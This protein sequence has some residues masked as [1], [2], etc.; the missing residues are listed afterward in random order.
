MKNGFEIE[1]TSEA[2]RNLNSIFDYLENSWSEREIS[3]FAKKMESDLKI[4]SKHPA[5]FPYF[6]KDKNVRRC[7]LTPQ[8]TIYYREIPSENRVVIITLFDNRQNPDNLNLILTP[9]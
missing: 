2:K 1:W 3:N 9:F 4:I 7:V 6:D 8:T 5:T